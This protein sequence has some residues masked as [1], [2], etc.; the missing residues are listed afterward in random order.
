MSELRRSVLDALKLAGVTRREYVEHFFG[1]GAS[2]WGDV[3]GCTDD[4]CAEGFHHYG[5]DD[6]QCFPVLLD[7]VLAARPEVTP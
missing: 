4:R 1:V 5:I 2:W 7:E 3:C 6:C